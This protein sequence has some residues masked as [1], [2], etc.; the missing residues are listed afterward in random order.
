MY[1]QPHWPPSGSGM[2]PPPPEANGWGRHV[3][4]MLAHLSAKVDHMEG[5]IERLSDHLDHHEETLADLREEVAR[6]KERSE[7]AEDHPHRPKPDKP[8]L[9]DRLK[10][11]KELGTGLLWLATASL[12][13]AHTFGLIGTDK[14]Q[15]LT[16]ILQ[17]GG[18]AP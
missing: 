2:P 18:A 10:A 17:G 6:L 9:E 13:V 15:K 16:A 5:W 8:S 4:A 7:Q 1:G 14:M 3:A 12:A 11:L